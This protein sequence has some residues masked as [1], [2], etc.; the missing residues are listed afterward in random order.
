MA[1]ADAG[2]T[3]DAAQTLPLPFVTAHIQQA[4]ATLLQQGQRCSNTL[5]QTTLVVRSSSGAAPAA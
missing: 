2:R 1:D 3:M 4:V 5:L